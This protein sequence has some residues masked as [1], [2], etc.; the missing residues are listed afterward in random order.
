MRVALALL[1]A[2]TFV[3][4]AGPR[5]SEAPPTVPTAEP[6]PPEALAADLIE[7]S[8]LVSPR[9]VAL[10]RTLLK[11]ALTAHARGDY[12]PAEELFKQALAIYPF[13]PQAN[14]ALGK[15]YLIRGS[16]QDDPTLLEAARRMFEMALALDPS[17]SESEQL[18]QLF[19][20]G[21]ER[22]LPLP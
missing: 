21:V 18:L 9:E 10:A 6:S 19:D 11:S 15:I 3:G 13:L 4:C 22:A 16:A 20:V 14:L 8:K 5:T 17:L 7:G 12:G 1:C 2:W